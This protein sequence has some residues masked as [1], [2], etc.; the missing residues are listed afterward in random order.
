M[1]ADLHRCRHGASRRDHSPRSAWMRAP[2][3]H[4]P[5]PPARHPCP[6]KTGWLAC[7]D[8]WSPCPRRRRRRARLLVAQLLG[9]A[10]A[11]RACFATFRVRG[12]L[13]SC[14]L[15]LLITREARQLRPRQSARSSRR[16]RGTCRACLHWG[17]VVRRRVYH[18]HVCVHA[19]VALQRTHAPRFAHPS[20]NL[21]WYIPAAPSS[22]LRCVAPRHRR[23]LHRARLRPELAR[24]RHHRS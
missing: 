4:R 2:T 10:N 5:A 18:V 21:I 6:P 16:V 23:H 3:R 13:T 9:A 1:L 19:L 14:A 7:L 12:R 20:S 15:R 17:Y 8:G 22:S 24:R 11:R